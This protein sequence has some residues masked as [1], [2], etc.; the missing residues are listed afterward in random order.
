MRSVITFFTKNSLW[1]N[2]LIFI[3]FLAGIV[4]TILINRSFFPEK[5]SN[6]ISIEARMEGSGTAVEVEQRLT[7][8]IERVVR[9]ISGIESFSSYTRENTSNVRVKLTSTKNREAKR[10]EID[11]EG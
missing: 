1:V 8:K 4:S 2:A 10:Q 6:E 11:L 7:A 9:T 3:I 5:V